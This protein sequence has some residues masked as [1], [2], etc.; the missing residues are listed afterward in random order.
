MPVE[1][2]PA[3][4]EESEIEPEQ[5]APLEQPEVLIMDATPVEDAECFRTVDV[6]EE[7]VVIEDQL[8]QV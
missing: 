6:E 4:T 3:H 2:E 5:E 8:M 7:V 1:S